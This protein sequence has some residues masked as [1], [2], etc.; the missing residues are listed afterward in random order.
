MDARVVNK[1]RLP[2]FLDRLAREQ[3]LI[4]PVQEED[5]ITLFKRVSGADE[6]TL[7]YTNSDVPPKVFFF[8]QTEKLL[9]FNTAG[10]ALEIKKDGGTEKRVLFGM[11]PC[12]IKSIEAMDP[13]FNG[14][15]K[16]EYFAE[17]REN[18]VMIGLSCSRV[19]S[20]CFCGAFNSG[21]CDGRGADL[22]FTE[23]GDCYY[24]EINTKKGH[25]L[26]EAHSQCFS[27]QGIAEA[28]KNKAERQNELSDSFFRKVDLKG[29]KEILDQHFELPY[30]DKISQKC[31]GCGICTFVCPTCHCFDIFDHVTGGYTGDRFRCWDSCMFSEFTRMAGG[32]NPRPSKKER[33]RNRFMH[34]LKYHLDRYQL[35]GCVGCGR[36]IEKCPVNMDITKIIKDLKEVGLNG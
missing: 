3:V 17:K 7:D 26:V 29:V 18:T 28:A 24:V 31:L 4:A 22:M 2:E 8:P 6:V 35:E 11:R 16:D 33:V 32:H 1:E 5:T 34:K 12:D 25:T 30:W 13:V 23:V 19:L 20:T 9:T 15:F 14:T 27:G 21:P 36:C 10:G